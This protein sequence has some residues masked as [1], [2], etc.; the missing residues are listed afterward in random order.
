M[1]SRG[2]KGRLELLAQVPL[3]RNC[4]NAELGAIVRLGTQIEVP[5]GKELTTEGAPGREFFLVL[6]GEAD[7]SVRGTTAKALGPGDY[8]GELALL[9]G[10][11]RTATVTAVTPLRLQVL[12]SG[13]F[14]SLLRASPDIAIKLLSNLAGRLR[15]SEASAL[16]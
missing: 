10:G 5:E 14:A 6:E 12:N 4:T 8:F 7:C 16:Y 15:D 3:F 13:E 1:R 11:S 9:D 2:Q